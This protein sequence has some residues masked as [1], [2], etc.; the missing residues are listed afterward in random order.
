MKRLDD[1][2]RMRS[3][4]A[5]LDVLK[6]FGTAFNAA[7]CSDVPLAHPPRVDIETARSACDALIKDIYTDAAF[8]KPLG[9]ALETSRVMIRVWENTASR[10]A[11]QSEEKDA[12]GKIE[13]DL[14]EAHK[15]AAA[16]LKAWRNKHWLALAFHG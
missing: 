1:L 7:I 16:I 14:A 10:L 4:V 15:Q 13:A 6:G 5:R 2:E 8:L 12:A 3:V 9:A 11:D